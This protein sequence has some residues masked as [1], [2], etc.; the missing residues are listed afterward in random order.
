LNRWAERAKFWRTIPPLSTAV[1]LAAVFCVVGSIGF[2]SVGANPDWG[3]PLQTAL[4][5][6]ISRGFGVGYILVATRHKPKALFFLIPIH[7][8]AI[9]LVSKLGPRAAAAFK[10]PPALEHRILLDNIGSMVLVLGGYILFIIFFQREGMRYFKAHTEIRL[11]GEIHRE[12]VPSFVSQ[13]G[14]FELYGVSQPSGEVGGDLV[15]VIQEGDRWFGYVAD[16]SGHGVP[17]GVMMAMVKSAV[18]MHWIPGQ[19]ASSLL[20]PLNSVLTAVRPQDMFVTCAYLQSDGGTTLRFSLAGHVP[21]LHFKAAT[22]TVAEHSILNFPLGLFPQTAFETSEIECSPGDVLVVLTDGLTEVFD[23]VGGGAGLG[24]FE[25]RP[26]GI[27]RRASGTNLAQPAT[28]G[29]PARTSVRRP[30]DAHRSPVAC[31]S[32]SHLAWFQNV[33]LPARCLAVAEH[34]LL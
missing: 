30:N 11:A 18:R 7:I 31:R 8:A 29:S 15:D 17:A 16:V 22:G 4:V 34:V 14:E 12:L 9:S 25:A 5:V 23:R 1:F 20:E 19:S 27:R 10:I 13:I 33:P 6:L 2:L 28:H 32:N 24:A 26:P 3:S 21:I